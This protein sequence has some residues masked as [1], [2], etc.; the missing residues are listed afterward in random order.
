METRPGVLSNESLSKTLLDLETS[1]I[2]ILL[3]SGQLRPRFKVLILEALSG[4]VW[5]S[6]P[7]DRALSSTG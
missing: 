5:K 4:K 7:A 6:W 3:N 2:V 1:Q